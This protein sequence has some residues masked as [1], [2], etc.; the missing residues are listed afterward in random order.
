MHTADSERLAKFEL[1]P[2]HTVWSA[3]Q[4]SLSTTQTVG[5]SQQ[6][7]KGSGASDERCVHEK[8]CLKIR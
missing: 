2:M 4:A 5:P 6:A 1:H 7:T 8:Y 3:F